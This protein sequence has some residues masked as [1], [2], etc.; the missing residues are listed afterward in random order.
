MDKHHLDQVVRTNIAEIAILHGAI[1]KDPN[2]FPPTIRAEVFA[3]L[4]PA[5]AEAINQYESDEEKSIAL[6][7]AITTTAAGLNG[8]KIPYRKKRYSCNLYQVIVGPPA[9]NKGISIHSR[10]ILNKVQTRLKKE[11]VVE[12]AKYKQT[13]KEKNQKDNQESIDSL[14]VKGSEEINIKSETINVKEKY[15]LDYQPEAPNQKHIILP[16]DISS[17]ALVDLVDR[18]EGFGLVFDS[19]AQTILNTFKQDWG[20]NLTSLLLKS[21]ENEPWELARKSLKSMIAIPEPR[22]SV[23]LTGNPEHLLGLVKSITNGLYSRFC[24]YQITS[25][26][27]KDITQFE[28]NKDYL[29][30]YISLSIIV[31]HINEKLSAGHALEFQISTGQMNAFNEFFRQ[32]HDVLMTQIH[33]EYSSVVRRMGAICYRIAAIL[34]AIRNDNQNDRLQCSD[35][36]FAIALS[37]CST[38]LQHSVYTFLTTSEQ[39]SPIQEF[40]KALERNFS[41]TEALPIADELGIKPRRMDSYLKELTKQ[42]KIRKVSHG[43]YEKCTPA[44]L[45]NLQFDMEDEDN[46]EGEEKMSLSVEELS[47]NVDAIESEFPQSEFYA[48]EIAHIA[49]LHPHDFDP[50]GVLNIET[51]H[52][53][54]EVFNWLD[55]IPPR[56]KLREWKIFD[57]INSD[58][59]LSDEECQNQL[60]MAIEYGLII[61]VSPGLYTLEPY[62][63][64][65]QN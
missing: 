6:L 26:G 43:Q 49:I 17:A 47:D 29:S 31:N 37:L 12:M 9:S 40:Y 11:Y 39:E 2:Y 1:L 7:S 4:P 3:S 58:R 54:V 52:S 38:L 33:L 62:S 18:N 23:L 63:G 8:I 35:E 45:Q 19:E 57:Y 20:A 13:I 24:I 46:L 60:Q 25:S 21:F 65:D 15:D 51:D 30:G 59:K 34:A 28:N 50:A 5:L 16:S 36:D 44:I 22:L 48:E 41:R 42:R 53:E 56:V 32:T 55:N 61:E 10:A 14:E 64:Y 27:W